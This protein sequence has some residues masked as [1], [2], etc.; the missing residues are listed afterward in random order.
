MSL[1]LAPFTSPKQY[2]FQ[3]VVS[4][5]MHLSTLRPLQIVGF[6]CLHLDVSVFIRT[7]KQLNHIRRHS[8]DDDDDDN[9]D[10]ELDIGRSVYHFL[11]C[12]YIPTRYTM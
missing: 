1:I 2:V 7:L 5:A 10:Y 11:Q 9:G 3:F 4:T 12:I 8:D 6:I